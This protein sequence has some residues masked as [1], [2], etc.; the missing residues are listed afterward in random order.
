[1]K[2]YYIQPILL[3]SIILPLIALGI[4]I[5][6]TKFA[7]SKLIGDFEKKERIY[8]KDMKQI[9]LLNKLKS[10]KKSQQE[11][12]AIWKELMTSDNNF[13]KI[14]NTFR[15]AKDKNDQTNTLQLIDIINESRV[16]S[17]AA[18]KHITLGVQATGTYSDLQH[19][20]LEAE[21]RSPNIM[22]NSVSIKPK[23][24]SKLLNLNAKY[25]LWVSEQ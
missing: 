7:T 18:S 22:L 2:K 4:G 3:F 17:G 20:L 5:G 1:M 25:T 16:I 15:D 10:E 21:S 8:D 12:L 14:R 6:L 11:E 19:C 9:K 23:S 13:A 24:N